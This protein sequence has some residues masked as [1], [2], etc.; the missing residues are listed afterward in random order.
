MKIVAPLTNIDNY[1]IL[2]ESGADEFYVGITP[3]EFIGKYAIEP[4][5][6]NRR[7][8]I[9]GFN[10]GTSDS[11]KIL[12]KKCDIYNK[13]VKITINAHYYIQSQ[14]YIIE[15]IIRKF[16]DYGFNTFIIADIALIVFLKEKDIKCKI[17]LSG[18]FGSINSSTIDFL[19]QFD[20]NR[21]I[22]P[23]NTSLIEM[24]SCIKNNKSYNIEYE[25][26]IL[27]EK[28]PYNSSYCN[29]FH[30]EN[31]TNICCINHYTSLVNNEPIKFKKLSN[32][33]TKKK[34][35]IKNKIFD[36]KNT[37]NQKP[38]LLINQSFGNSG[39]GICKLHELG[40]LGIEYV[41]VVG[42]GINIDLILRDI[43]IIKTLINQMEY[44]NKSNDYSN[45]FKE[46]LFENNCT[47]RCYYPD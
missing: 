14:Y 40:E 42:R 8:Y 21:I 41:K 38:I 3:Y 20:I 22:F 19:M 17:H 26:F 11:L 5:A 29:S 46:Y 47:Q 44:F 9:S 34:I 15:K 39:C 16:I 7:P 6:L 31:I 37:N 35:L 2:V 32:E 30:S 10:L 24:K 25:S 13:P 27:N 28:C 33:I 1:E 12:R 43:K 36:L 23:R 4:F 18:D 45:Y